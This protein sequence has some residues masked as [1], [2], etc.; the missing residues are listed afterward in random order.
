MKPMESN[1]DCVG[2]AILGEDGEVRRPSPQW[3]RANLQDSV[4]EQPEKSG[5]IPA[6]S[7][8]HSHGMGLALH[9]LGVDLGNQDPKMP[10]YA[11]LHGREIHGAQAHIENGRV[12]CG[13]FR[14]EFPEDRS[15][16]E[17]TPF[18]EEL[19]AASG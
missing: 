8:V 12:Y 15:E 3:G 9:G 17:G 7:R 2:A 19:W 14:E 16:L 10:E 4:P 13:A 11:Q 1:E 6:F 5:E 18:V